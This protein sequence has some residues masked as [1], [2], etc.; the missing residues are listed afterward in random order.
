MRYKSPN[1]LGINFGSGIDL[2]KLPP[3]AATI[4]IITIFCP[5]MD[6]SFIIL[7]ALGT[8]P[9]IITYR[10]WITSVTET[11]RQKAATRQIS[12]G[13][14]LGFGTDLGKIIG[15]IVEPPK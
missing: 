8:T 13:V 14:S 3:C 11:T 5:I 2:G 12:I 6:F 10:I 7:R 15:I 4:L 1:V 9:Y